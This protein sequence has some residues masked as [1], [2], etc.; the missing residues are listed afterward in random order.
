[1]LISVNSWLQSTTWHIKLDGTGNF[2]TIQQGIDA[3]AD[4]DTVLVYPGTYFE[5][6]YLENKNITLASL[7]LTTGN[8][9]YVNST[10]IDGQGIESCIYLNECQIGVVIQGFTIQ[11]GS[12]RERYD[13]CRTGGGVMLFES[14]SQIKN[15]N[16]INN[17]AAS[18]GGILS[19]LSEIILAN[20]NIYQNSANKGGGI[21][22]T[23]S[24]IIYFDPNNRNSIYNNNAAT[25]YDIYAQHCNHVHVVLDTFSIEIPDEYYA[26][27]FDQFNQYNT[28]FTFDIEVGLH[29][30]IS[31]DL[32]VSGDGDDSNSGL[33]FAEPLRNISTAVR[34]IDVSSGTNRTI[35][36]SSGTYS[37]SSNQQIF[38]FGLKENLTIVGEDNTNTFIVNDF[39]QSTFEGFDLDGYSEIMNFSFDIN[40]QYPYY[41]FQV[42]FCNSLK[43]M[44]CNFTGNSSTFYNVIAENEYV[45]IDDVTIHDASTTQFAVCFIFLTNGR[46]NNVTL[47]NCDVIN[48]PSTVNSTL[49]LTSNGEFVLENCKLINNDASSSLGYNSAN[50]SIAEFFPYVSTKKI[51]NCLFAN[52]N[53][54][55]GYNVRINGEGEYYFNNCTFT[56]NN[57]NLATLRVNG[58]V[59]MNNTIMYNPDNSYEISMYPD[60]GGFIS[61]LD[62]SHS[63]IRNGQDGI[64]NSG[65]QQIVNWNEGNI[66][67]DPQFLLSGEDPY[68]LSDIS[69]CIDTGSTDTTGLF[70]PPWDLLHHQ[71]IWDGDSNGIATIDMGC[72]EYGA[73]S[74]G[75]IQNQIPKVPYQISN[76]PNPFNPSTTIAFNLPLAGQVIIEIYNI[77]GQKVKT[78]MDCTT[79]PGTYECNWNGKD[80]TGKSVSS[81]QYVVKLKQNGKETAT[82]I[83][84]LK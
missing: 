60:S 2:T 52:N 31:N 9:Q 83:M 19:S 27:S 47:D 25:G 65:N 20:N 44:S 55:G 21:A 39:S 45:E 17:K 8:P 4:S 18:G 63:N 64:Y 37:Y 84:L 50:I 23:D 56:N 41:L 69:P 42:G 67:E 24:S 36:V 68:Q 80:D 53:A 66:V 3:S 62:V 33:S 61:T 74:V 40:Y 30:L 28:Y 16:I 59:H 49:E 38:P 35:H 70:L 71:R 81:G 48:G 22:L 51:V 29:E 1:V 12:G 72:Y 10:I 76:Y 7:E 73:D 43:I 58:N 57:S 26:K 6:I 32:Y 15:N 34:L 82:K 54:D 5:N 77:K 75:V 14:I 11:N 13:F 78:L 46:M 79:V